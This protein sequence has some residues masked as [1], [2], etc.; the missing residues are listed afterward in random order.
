MDESICPVCGANDAVQH[1]STIVDS[2]T[3]TTM[4]GGLIFAGM[5]QGGIAPMLTASRTT[6][7]LAKRL[8]PHT[9]TPGNVSWGGVLGIFGLLALVFA[10]ILREMVFGE[11]PNETL[12][13][14]VVTTIVFIIPG[15]LLSLAISLVLVIIYRYSRPIARRRWF[16]K[17]T[18]LYNAR[19]CF[20]DDVVFD[21]YQFANPETYLNYLFANNRPLTLNISNN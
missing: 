1:V 2:G 7:N 19:Y 18:L 13:G 15:I 9:L 4:G 10:F 5:G 21:D 3:Q 17:A 8:S 20:R 16:K 6:N 12:G 14:V 11:T